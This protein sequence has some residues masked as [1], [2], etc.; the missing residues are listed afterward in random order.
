M[1][2]DVAPAEPPRD[3]IAVAHPR[4]PLARRGARTGD[5]EFGPKGGEAGGGRRRVRPRG[6]PHPRPVMRQDRRMRIVGGEDEVQPHAEGAQQIER[7]GK[8]G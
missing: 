4:P 2:G 7:R 6:Q 3:E 8:V 1:R 5:D